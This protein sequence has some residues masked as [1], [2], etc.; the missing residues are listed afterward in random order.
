MPLA[1]EK[2]V[3]LTALNTLGITAAADYLARITTPEQIPEAI[4][5]AHD[6]QLPWLVLGQG[7]NIVIGQT[8]LRCVVLKIEVKGR[9]A[10]PSPNHVD[11]RVGAGEDWDAF[12]DWTVNQGWQG[13]EALSLVPGTVG[14]T[15]V[16]NVGAYGQEVSTVITT[17]EASDLTTSQSVTLTNADCQFAYR[18]SIFKHGG[19]NRYII[20]AVT[21]RLHRSAPPAPSYESLRAE[22]HR[23]SIQ[24]PTVG[25]IRAAVIAIRR[26]KLPD[27]A[28]TPTAG[29]FFH[30]PIIPAD[31]FAKLQANYP[32]IPHWPAGRG[33]VKL[34]AAWLIEQCGFKGAME[35]G[36]GTYPKQALALINPGHRPATD[37]LAFRDKVMAAVQDRFGITLHM[38]PELI[39]L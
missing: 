12:V 31:A 6:H 19:K 37:V 17:V 5:F 18:D 4:A 38:E 24:Q 13:I 11:I 20:T 15:P 33:S 16:Q 10:T 39:Q 35:D 1:I 28:V 29:S 21:F 9:H 7:S 26:S 2:S 22:L 34:S 3:D 23:R 30:N 27:P 32:D 8:R 14:A 36:V 25:D